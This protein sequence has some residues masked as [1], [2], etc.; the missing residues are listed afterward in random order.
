[1]TKA[2]L[3]C[4]ETYHVEN[5]LVTQ[6]EKA[7]MCNSQLGIRSHSH[8]WMMRGLEACQRNGKVYVEP[9]GCHSVMH[10]SACVGLVFHQLAVAAFLD[11][12]V[13]CSHGLVDFVFGVGAFEEEHLAV[14]LESEDVGTNSVEEPA[15]V[16]DDYCTSGK[17]F[18][19]FF[20]CTE[21]VHVDIVGRLVEQQHVSLLLQCECELQTV[22][23][24]ARKYTA[25]FALV[26]SGEVET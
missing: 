2:D 6:T 12:F 17:R 14:A 9:Y 16:T 23:L 20:E 22:S 4:V 5:Q 19:T 15:V 8:P 3:L 7:V 11:F 24:T 13:A 1:M 26:G 25:E 10:S 21:R 18:Q